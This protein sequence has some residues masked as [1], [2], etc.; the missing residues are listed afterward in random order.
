MRMPVLG[1]GVQRGLKLESGRV[2]LRPPRLGDW[3]TWA[4][5]REASRAFLT[6]WEPTWPQDALSGSAFRRRVRAHSQEW[7]DGVGYAF[8]IF[9]R[10]DDQ[11]VGGVTLSNVRRGVC[12]CASLGY[13]TGQVHARQGHMTEALVAA[14]NFSF[15]DLALHRLEAACLPNNDASRG[16]L[17]KMGFR[18]EGYAKRYLRINGQWRDHVLFAMLCEDWR[19]RSKT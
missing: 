17:V 6:P 9:R 16:L 2:Y 18:E 19:V 1:P 10:R 13:W 7:R 5:L 8:L 11:L 12:Q 4:D 15:D 14:L 3:R